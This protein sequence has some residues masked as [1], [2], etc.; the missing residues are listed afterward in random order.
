MYLSYLNSYSHIPN[1]YNDK[2]SVKL[3]T[4]ENKPESILNL[5]RKKDETVLSNTIALSF[6]SNF[7][8]INIEEKNTKRKKDIN[9]SQLKN[10]TIIKKSL[11]NGSSKTISK[12]NNKSI[13]NS[14]INNKSINKSY[15][16]DSKNSIRKNNNNND[17]SLH[18]NF[19]SPKKIKKIVQTKKNGKFQIIK[20]IPMRRSMKELL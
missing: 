20:D 1:K 10:S 7:L 8:D 3:S 19:N 13:N 15:I 17:N 18:L 11:K 2:N 6:I 14:N 4:R 16:N 9:H 12:D 5:S